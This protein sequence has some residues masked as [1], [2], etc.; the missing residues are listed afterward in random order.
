MKGVYQ[1]HSRTPDI[2]VDCLLKVL[3]LYISSSHA[4]LPV[5]LPAEEE[6]VL[7]GAGILA[8]AAARNEEVGG[9]F[10]PRTPLYWQS[11]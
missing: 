5:V 2:S 1:K 6:S 8:A 7:L 3:Q 4:G 11:L 9:A 10:G